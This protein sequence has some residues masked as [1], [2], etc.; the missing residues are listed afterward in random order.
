M[1]IINAYKNWSGGL[2]KDNYD[3]MWGS[4]TTMARA[5]AKGIA[6][7]GRHVKFFKL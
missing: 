4:T 6:S 7:Q 1:K 3:I 2:S 5:I